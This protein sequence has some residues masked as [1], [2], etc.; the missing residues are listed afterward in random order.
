[1]SDALPTDPAE[2]RAEIAALQV[3][4]ARLT[5]TLRA[6]DLLIEALRAR[7]A[8]LQR[9]RFGPSSE[10]IER[11]IEQ[12]ELALE[13]LQVAA[14]EGETSEPPDPDADASAET[15][16]EKPAETPKP[17]RR[18]R[19]AEGTPRER[20]V[21]EPGEACP[22]CGGDLRIVGEDVSELVE[23]IAAKLK[24]IEIAR[25]KAS[26]RRCER[27]VQAP[28]PSRPIPRSMAGP[29]L[30]AHILVSKVDDH[31]PLYRQAEV[32]SRMSDPALVRI[33][34]ANASSGG[35]GAAHEAGECGAPGSSH[36]G[37]LH[38]GG[39]AH[40]VD[41]GRGDEMLKMR[42]GHA[43]VARATQTHGAHAQGQ[44][45]LD[46]GAPPPVGD[47]RRLMHTRSRRALGV[48]CSLR[49]RG[50]R[51]RRAPR[52]QRGLDG[53]ALHCVVEKRMRI[54][55]RPRSRSSLQLR[56]SWPSG[57]VA[58]RRSQSR[59]KSSSMNAP[60]VRPCHWLSLG[61]GPTRATP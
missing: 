26:C 16:A 53:H 46:A 6:H 5:A 13:D 3:E 50:V 7:I 4:N 15:E 33:L 43:D 49:G 47:E 29:G 1:M 51:I 52:V 41:R 18:P 57:Q 2:L 38:P 56:L 19:V 58:T 20:R 8:K 9:Q 45:A 28:A 35:C 22:D 12:F 24:V 55:V 36:R 25:P 42:F 10:K 44:R 14:A 54:V 32:F 31:V 34:L 59:A 40:E 17:C 37:V 30:L 23:L 48:S 60:L 39:E 21:L 11:E 27:M 61:A